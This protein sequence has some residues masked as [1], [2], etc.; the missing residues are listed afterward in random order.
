MN[1]SKLLR[2]VIVR[3][4]IAAIV[5]VAAQIVNASAATGPSVK[6]F[7]ADEASA[8][9]NKG[10]TLY[11][12]GGDFRIEA[13]RRDHPGMVEIHTLDTDVIYVLAGTTTFVTGGTMVGGKN[14]A[15]N[16]VRGTSMDGG[17]I[18][19]LQRAT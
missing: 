12:S 15:P 7:L 1:K 2:Y 3:Y 6:F 5:T 14:V 11:D 9:F 8:A 18:A 10:T 4:A 13:G 16:E 19:T 17:E